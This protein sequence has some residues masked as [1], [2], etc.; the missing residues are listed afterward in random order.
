MKKSLFVSMVSASLMLSGCAAPIIM[1]AAAT[2]GYMASQERGFK[3]SLH[4]TKIKAHLKDR[5]TNTHYTY[6]AEIGT[7]V[8]NGDVLVTGVVESA[9]EKAKVMSVVRNVPDV[10]RVFDELIVAPTYSTSERGKDTWISA[11]IK[12]G[13]VKSQD[14]YAINYMTEVIKGNV[15]IMGLATSDA[16]RE[17]VLYIARTVKGVKKVV[18]YIQISRREAGEVYLDSAPPEMNPTTE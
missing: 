11:Q 16:E 2:G 4:D 13:L 6:L 5:L 3:T 15:Y 1:G 12:A 7:S 14:V 9:D 8:L 18:N 17:R 10:K